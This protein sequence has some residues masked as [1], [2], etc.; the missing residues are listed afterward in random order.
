MHTIVQKSNIVDTIVHL[1]L[2]STQRVR[3]LT[4]IYKDL[5][6]PLPKDKRL[7]LI[8]KVRKILINENDFPEFGEVWQIEIK[9]LLASFYAMN[10]VV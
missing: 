10:I 5:Q 8:N 9:L 6:K 3:F 1:D 4:E 2:L 7:D